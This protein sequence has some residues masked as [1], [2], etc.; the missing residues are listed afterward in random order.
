ME[1][2]CERDNLNAAYK[3][4]YRNRGIPG[5]DN[6]S[7]DALKMW[8]Q[9][10]KDNLIGSLL[11]GTYMP[12]PVKGIY[13]PKPRKRGIRCIGVLSVIDRLVQNAI[14]QV[15]CDSIDKMF[16]DHSF[17]FRRNRGALDAIQMAK[18]YVLDGY[19]YVA[20]IDIEKF[21]DN[22]HHD[23]VMYKLSRIVCDK[24]V[25]K[26][27]RR[28]L[29][30]GMWRYD[31][32]IER[33][34]GVYQG[35]SLSP[36]LSNLML[37]EVDVLL[38]QRE[39]KFCRYADD[40]KVYTKSQKAADRVLQSIERYLAQH[41]KLKCNARKTKACRVQDSEFLGYNIDENGR[42][43]AI[44]ENVDSLKYKIKKLTNRSVFRN[45]KIMI[46][47]LNQIIVGWTS[48]FRYDYRQDI[49]RDL[50]TM[51]RRRIRANIIRRAVILRSD[52]AAWLKSI[53]CKNCNIDFDKIRWNCGL[54]TRRANYIIRNEWF[55]ENHLRS[56]LQSKEKYRDK[57]RSRISPPSRY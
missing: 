34:S 31:V 4:V 52:G 22:I 19:K 16:S 37:H 39:H 28:F 36:L 49:Y 27:I 33:V 7:V 20:D 51:L 24:R 15:I 55:S 17:G 29:Q 10:N 1:V 2:I 41:L 54:V 12:R 14:F 25:L 43:T 44:Q 9:T 8:L 48:Y 21:F 57:D 56:I 23:K 40:I 18:N 50:D 13:I 35:G 42:I 46:S 26:I 32:Y 6:I 30:A 47:E 11:D 3:K 53:G 45:L 38:E 5:I